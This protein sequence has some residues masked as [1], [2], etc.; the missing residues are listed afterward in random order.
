MMK[1][2]LSVTTVA[3]ALWLFGPLAMAGQ[4]EDKVALCAGCHGPNG[5]SQVPD[6]PILAG[7][8]PDYLAGALRAYT[9]GGRDYAIMKTLAGRLSPGDIEVISAYYAAQ[10]PSQSQARAAGDAARGETLTAVCAACH[11]PGGHSAIPANPKLAGQHAKYLSHAL[12]AY[13]NGGRTNPVMAPMAANLS[14]QDIADIAAYY[15]SQPVQ[16]AE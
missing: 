4:A 12:A 3:L 2:K 15:A 5:H 8:H 14:E 1:I 9:D 16:S 11:G 10:P 7:Q 6:N 13:K